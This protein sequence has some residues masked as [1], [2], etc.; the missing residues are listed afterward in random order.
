MAII[1]RRIFVRQASL[2][3]VG[4][5][6]GCSTH[7]R[8]RKVSRK[9]HVAEGAVF[10]DLPYPD[11]KRIPL[12]W[13]VMPVL[14]KNAEFLETRLTFRRVKPADIQAPCYLR[15]TA[16]L[17]FR[18]E[19]H[20]LA[21]LSASGTELGL[22]IMKYAYPFQ[23]FEIPIEEKHLEGIFREGI[24]LKLTRGTSEAWFY[25]PDHN[26]LKV[27]D[28]Y[29]PHLLAGQSNDPEEAFYKN[30]LSMNSFSP[31]G[32][33]GGCVHDALYEMHI[34]GHREALSA[35]KMHL[36]CY[37][38]DEK[39]IVFENPHTIAL[40][41][42]FNSVEDF[43]PF[44]SIAALYPDH[45]SIS[46]ALDFIMSRRNEQGLIS[47]GHITTE[48]CY[49]L[50][51][52]L[53][54]IAAIRNDARLAQIAVDQLTHRM[55]YLTETDAV[56]QR[57][58]IN[59]SKSYRNWGR[60]VTWYLL[61]IIKTLRIIDGN[62]FGHIKGIDDI[63]SSFV[64]LAKVA[65]RHADSESMWHSYIDNHELGV[66]TSSTGGIATAITLGVRQ[67]L[68]DKKYLDLTERSYNSLLNYLSAD[69]FLRN[70]SQI[71]RGGEDLQLSPYR[72]IAQF[73]MGLMAQLR[74]SLDG[75]ANYKMGEK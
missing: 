11:G 69:G 43:L 13:N 61:G 48:G 38:D 53:S 24:T 34:N 47:G 52:P 18:E 40:D 36:E 28:G 41:G 30:L 72:V 51:Y 45:I 21:C 44:S 23:P 7:N 75:P 27:N 42:T 25:M 19:K 26:F 57:S 9:R 73:G 37:L 74:V 14:E 16:A 5:I 65:A 15:I 8:R 50:A 17:D 67:G 35:L 10:P 1:S 71:N 46:K 66:D 49:T 4:I 68:L 54:A 20:V 56:Y 32:W 39:G 12:G 62:N 55:I 22:F 58:S 31:F 64:H 29:Q 3:G 2:I 60:G 6:S 33:I 59:G 70:V 63:K